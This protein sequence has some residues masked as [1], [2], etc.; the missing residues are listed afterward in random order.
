MKIS[1]FTLIC[2]V[3]FLGGCGHT[4]DDFHQPPKISPVTKSHRPIAD[5][6]I[7]VDQFF[8]APSRDKSERAQAS[9]WNYGPQSLL[10]DRR[11]TGLGD[12]LTVVVSIDE[13]A[14]MDNRTQ[15]DRQAQEEVSVPAFLGVGT[16]A[17]RILPGGAGLDQ[18][19]NVSSSSTTEGDGRILRRERITLRV[20]ATVRRV[21]PNGYLLI[22][23]SQE[24][25]VNNELR[26][27]QVTGIVRTQDIARTNEITYDK[28]AEARITYGGRGIASSVQDQRYGQKIL[29]KIIPF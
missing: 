26:D 2:G 29:D 28:I 1:G 12:I 14:Q 21:L 24:V 20:A 23:G 10:G 15:V 9:L 3:I 19:I 8:P 25:R 11:A 5:E 22:A 18:A 6:E 17:Q 16:L 27:L 13:E 7:D 4:L